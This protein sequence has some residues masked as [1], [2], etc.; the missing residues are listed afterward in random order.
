MLCGFHRSLATSPSHRH[1]RTAYELCFPGAVTGSTEINCPHCG[2]LLTV[3]VNDPMGQ[4]SYQ[5]SECDGTFEVDWGEGQ[6]R[7]VPQS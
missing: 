7:F 4:E 1:T 2:D 3:T 6:V 5:C